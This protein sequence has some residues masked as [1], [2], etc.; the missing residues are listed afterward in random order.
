MS[1]RGLAP[2]PL[3]LS[4]AVEPRP[5]IGILL[6]LAAI[7]MF[8]TLDLCAKYLGQRLPVLEV[9]WARYFG[10][11]AIMAVFLLPRRGLGLLRTGRPALQITRSLLLLGCTVGFFLAISYMPLADA[12]AIGFIS[13]LAVTALSVPLLREPVGIR[14]WSAVAIGFIGALIIVRPGLGVVHWAAFVVLAVAFAYALYQITT[15]MLAATDDPLTTLFY[16]ALVGAALLTLAVPF[17]WQTPAEPL[18]IAL[19]VAVGAIGGFGHYLLIRAHGLTPVAVLAPLT[20][21]S[22]L[23]N[24]AYG[25]AFFGDLPDQWTVTG[26]AILIATGLY[27]LYREGVRR[28]ERVSGD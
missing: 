13:P 11:F 12:A 25:Y 24:T 14:R 3:P 19:M 22:L 8:S 26:A 15:R 4:V 17:V 23:W 2:P 18:E 9:A 7:G 5:L 27:V 6:M 28:K 16:S 1:Q 20:Y 21:T 10:H